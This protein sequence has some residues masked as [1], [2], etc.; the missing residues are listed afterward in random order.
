MSVLL[1]L[2]QVR[3]EVVRVFNENKGTKEQ[4][5]EEMEAEIGQQMLDFTR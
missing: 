2:L 5:Q 4:T 3:E 1:A